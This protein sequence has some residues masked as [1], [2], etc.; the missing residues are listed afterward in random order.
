[1]LP[2]LQM[3]LFSTLSLQF[4]F[5]DVQFKTCVPRW[6]GLKKQKCHLHQRVP[7]GTSSHGFKL[8]LVLGNS[9]RNG[10]SLQVQRWTWV[11]VEINK[12]DYC[13]LSSF[14][15]LCFSKSHWHNYDFP[16]GLIKIWLIDI[17]GWQTGERP[18]IQFSLLRL[19]FAEALQVIKVSFKKKVLQGKL[20]HG[21]SDFRAIRLFIQ[22]VYCSLFLLKQVPLI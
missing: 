1:M 14:L 2:P 12:N 11:M 5:S 9:E 10:V 19:D 17:F 15:I 8:P 7:C 3:E 6:K 21:V 22:N 18:M 16:F 20:K 4:I 13:F